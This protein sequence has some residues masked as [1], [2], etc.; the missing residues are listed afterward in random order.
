M[1]TALKFEPPVRVLSKVHVCKLIWQ[2]S[3]RSR[4]IKEWSQRLSHALESVCITTHQRYNRIVSFDSLVRFSKTLLSNYDSDLLWYTQKTSRYLRV[5]RCFSQLFVQNGQR[6]Y[7]DS[8]Q[9]RTKPW[10][11]SR[12]RYLLWAHLCYHGGAS[13]EALRLSNYEGTIHNKSMV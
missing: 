8:W 4:F 9:K 2:Q 10:V 12:W 11:L 6:T 1:S 5:L 3:S 7:G 13:P